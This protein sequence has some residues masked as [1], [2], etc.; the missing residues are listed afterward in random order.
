MLLLLGACAGLTV[1]ASVLPWRIPLRVSVLVALALRIVVAT[2]ATRHTPTDVSSWFHT[3]A[4]LVSHGRDPITSMPRYQWNFLP[5]LPYLW[6]VLLHLHQSWLV[7]DKA[8]AIAADCVN[9]VLV[10]ALATTRKRTR[11]FQYAVSPLALLV[12][13]W[14]GQIEPIVLAC[15]LGALVLLRRGKYASAGAL[16]GLGAAIK[17]WPIVFALAVLRGAPR[18][19]R[20]G[21]LAGIAAVPLVMFVTMPLFVSTDLV[22]DAGI[23]AGYASRIGSFGWPAVVNLVRGEY[24]SGHIGGLFTVENRIST[25]LLVIATVL[26]WRVWREARA[27]VFML[28]VLLSFLV[29]SAGF[30]VQYLM[31]PLPLALACATRRTWLY[32]WPATAYAFVAYLHPYHLGLQPHLASAY[33]IPVVLGALFALPID[34]RVDERGRASRPEPEPAGDPRAPTEEP[35]AA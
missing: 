3:T 6:S 19:R 13:S 10:A 15:C 11:A 26:V 1:A 33:S 14:H 25:I 31:W 29:V 22:K 16:V 8:L 2:I 20:L 32:I 4:V 18:R 27:E 28:A 7:T 9:V 23:I 35:A 5:T 12:V 30:G 24:S 17:T 21:V 34:Q